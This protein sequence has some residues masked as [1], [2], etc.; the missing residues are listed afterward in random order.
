[1]RPGRR[2]RASHV[3]AAESRKDVS[4]WKIHTLLAAGTSVQALVKLG[5]SLRNRWV[6]V[7][8]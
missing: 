4:L 3:A 8:C 5:R 1:M 2:T 6:E 7:G